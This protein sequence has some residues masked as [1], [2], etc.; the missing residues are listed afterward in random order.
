MRV[1]ASANVEPVAAGS[2]IVE[3]IGKPPY[4]QPRT[5]RLSGDSE[6]KVAF[7]GIRLFTA[8][9]EQLVQ[10]DAKCL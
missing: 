9:M 3:V 4:D 1:L 5:Y 8:E 6:S 7:E 2:W 10:G